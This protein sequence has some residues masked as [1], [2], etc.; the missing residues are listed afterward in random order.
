MIDIKILAGEYFVPVKLNMV[1]NRVE[2]HF[3]YN[4]SL[5]NEIKSMEGAKYHGF[6]SVNPRKIWSIPLTQRNRFQLDYLQGKNPYIKYDR[7]VIDF[8]SSRPLF[9]HQHDL[10]AAALAF[11]YVIWAA[12]MGTGKSLAAIETMEHT[13]NDDLRR[14]S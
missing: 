10:S 5:I 4:A 8:K 3:K 13:H 2:F 1:G 9:K 6:D 12:E 7:P 11:H 14:S